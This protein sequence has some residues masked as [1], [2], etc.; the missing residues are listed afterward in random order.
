MSSPFRVTCDRCGEPYFPDKADT[1]FDVGYETMGYVSD[2]TG[3]E[4]P[5][6]AWRK[7]YLCSS[8]QHDLRAEFYYR[9]IMHHDTR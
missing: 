6:K 2:V 9:G 8:C 3:Q 5:E 1:V 7:L 4:E